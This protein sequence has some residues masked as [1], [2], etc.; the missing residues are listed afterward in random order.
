LTL[1]QMHRSFAYSAIMAGSIFKA[2]DTDG[3]N[4]L[5]SD[6]LH[7]CFKDLLL[8]KLRARFPGESD[9]FYDEKLNQFAIMMSEEF[10]VESGE[11]VKANR[12][13][14]IS[15]TEFIRNCTFNEALDWDD[16][17]DKLVQPDIDADFQLPCRKRKPKVAPSYIGSGDGPS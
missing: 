12:K 13:H 11:A 9:G 5:D 7:A 2:L 17:M 10:E 8:P 16:M 3:D 4:F 6:E 14:G 15:H 1:H